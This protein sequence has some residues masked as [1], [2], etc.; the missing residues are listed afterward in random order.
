MEDM[1]AWQETLHNIIGDQLVQPKRVARRLH[2]HF[3]YLSDICRRDRVDPFAV[4]NAI[5]Q[6]AEAYAHTDPQRMLAIAHRVFQL[7]TIGTGFYVGWTSPSAISAKSDLRDLRKHIPTLLNDLAGV[8]E[9]LCDIA[10]DHRIDDSDDASIEAFGFKVN[11]LN[12]LLSRL[13]IEVH[14]RRNAGVR[15]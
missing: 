4:F 12:Q 9:H 6:E 8:V 10:E 1:N 7:L 14:A 2:R 13:H 15:Q 5:L 3:D 11:R